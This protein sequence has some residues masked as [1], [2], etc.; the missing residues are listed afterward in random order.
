MRSVLFMALALAGLLAL[1][2]CSDSEYSRRPPM[3][4]LPT[5]NIPVVPRSPQKLARE[6]NIKQELVASGKYCRRKPKKLSPAYITIHSTQNMTAGAEQHAL[7]L[8]NGRIRGGAIGYL[9]WHFTVD[10]GVAVQHLPLNEIGHHA[11]YGY[12]T[13]NMRSIGIEMCENRGNSLVRTYDRTAKLAAVL[14]KRYNIPL[15]NVVPHNFWTGKNC[16]EKLLDHGRPGYRWNWFQGR[17]DYY[18]RCI[19]GGVSFLDK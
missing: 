14:M 19:N 18:Y 11:E 10:Q 9:S 15:R 7:A 5:N 17:V 3:V 2:S 13:G 4:V 12:K 8:R 16:P 6:A 1:V